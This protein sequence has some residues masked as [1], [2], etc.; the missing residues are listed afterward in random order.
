MENCGQRVSEKLNCIRNEMTHL[1]GSV[2]LIL[3]GS[4]SIIF[5]NRNFEGYLIGAIGIAI[6]LILAYAY[7][8]RREETLRI[9]NKIDEG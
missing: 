3:G 5:H 7:F 6:A 8:I 2:F 9:I 1:W 4:I